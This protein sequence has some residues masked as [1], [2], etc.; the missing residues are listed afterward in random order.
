MS[1][2]TGAKG[3]HFYYEPTEILSPV[4]AKGGG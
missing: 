2:L 1:V 3:T 4:A